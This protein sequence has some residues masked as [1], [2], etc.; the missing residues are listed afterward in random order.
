[1]RP[2]WRL[3]ADK[4]LRTWNATDAYTEAYPQ[5]TRATAGRNGHKLL[6]NAEIHAYI[7]D[8]QMKP[9]EVIGRLEEQGR[10][11]YSQFIN[12]DGEVDIQ[13]MKDAGKGHLIKGISYDRRGNRIVHFYDGQT[14]LIY[15][16]K[17]HK[18]FTDK[19]ELDIG[20]KLAA[21]LNKFSDI[22][23]KIYAEPAGAGKV[24]DDSP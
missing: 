12:A 16:G 24:P 19:T 7:H 21:K 22:L 10:S 2:R 11:E 18:M 3:F 5:C 4:Y 9:E 17:H 20:D 6:K 8:H 15:I 14:A 13:A 23:E 1:M